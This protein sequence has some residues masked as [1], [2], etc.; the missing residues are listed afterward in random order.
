MSTSLQRMTEAAYVRFTEAAVADYADD[1]VAAGRWPAEGAL[2]R[3]RL[4]QERLLPQGLAT[5]GQHL[6]TIHDDASGAAVGV[7]W[8]SVTEH[9]GGRSGYVYDVAIDPPHRRRGHA[10]AAFLA[11][12][13]VA[14]ELGVDDIGLHVFAHNEGAQ[15]L[16]LALG[17]EPTGINM[18]K[19]LAP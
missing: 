11:L 18:K 5:P 15:A 14:R 12:E 13:A 9:P 7:L 16:Y 8:L 4:E 1:N 6:F 17:Y 2:E 3:S 19:R 10:R